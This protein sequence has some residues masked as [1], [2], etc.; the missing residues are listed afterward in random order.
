[1]TGALAL[2]Y[3]LSEIEHFADVVH[4]PGNAD[5]A[6]DGYLVGHARW[7]GGPEGSAVLGHLRQRVSRR[8]ASAMAPPPGSPR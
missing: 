1:M 2:E 6:Y 4:S 7:F 3:A 5:L 8:S